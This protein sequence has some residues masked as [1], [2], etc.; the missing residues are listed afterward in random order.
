M[1]VVNSYTLYTLR[2]P[3]KRRRMMHVQ[4]CIT[5]ATD[6]LHAAC[7]DTGRGSEH[8]GPTLQPSARLTERHFPTVIGKT[9]PGQPIQ[10][11]CTV[12]SKRCVVPCSELTL[13]QGIFGDP[14]WCGGAQSMVQHT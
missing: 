9:P 8:H 4:F 13:S 6:L 1:A 14:F 7:V 3:D 11:D 12:C 5:L 2:N 10:W